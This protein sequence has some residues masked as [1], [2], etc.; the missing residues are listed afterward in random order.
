MRTG[1]RI[2][3][4]ASAVALMLSAACSDSSNTTSPKLASSSASGLLG[5]LT[6]TLTSLLVQPLQRTTTLPADVS[7]SFVAGPGGATS[8]NSAVGLTVAIPAGALGSN[9]TITVTALAGSPVAY[10]FEPHSLIFA[11][12]AY[13]TQSLAGTTSGLLNLT[14]SGAYFSTDRLQVNGAGLATVTEILSALVNPLTRTVT[15]GIQHFSGYIVA[16][17]RSADSEDF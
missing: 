13:L 12:K 14:L 1:L 11:K 6:N 10:T 16:S 17:G 8:T 3:V 5:G 7:W 4:G 2:A 9:Q 15:F